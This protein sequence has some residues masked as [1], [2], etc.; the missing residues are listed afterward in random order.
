M[1]R[2]PAFVVVVFAVALRGLTKSDQLGGDIEVRPVDELGGQEKTHRLL[3]HASTRE[4]YNVGTQHTSTRSGVINSHHH[5]GRRL[6][7]TQSPTSWSISGN[8]IIS[9]TQNFTF[10][11]GSGLNR[12]VGKDAAKA[13]AAARMALVSRVVPSP[14]APQRVTSKTALP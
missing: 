6:L 14:T 13:V 1:S 3:D 11:G 8:K 5:I 12:A 7:S 2:I 4:K 9:V 10:T